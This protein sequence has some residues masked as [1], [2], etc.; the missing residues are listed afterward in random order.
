MLEGFFK[1]MMGS[2]CTNIFPYGK[3]PFYSLQ[4]ATF[5]ALELQLD[6]LSHQVKEERRLDSQAP[7]Y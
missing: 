2:Q 1:T 5:S 7:G 6:P 3:S 4:G